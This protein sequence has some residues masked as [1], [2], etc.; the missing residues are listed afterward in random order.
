MREFHCTTVTAD[1]AGG[2]RFAE[3]RAPMVETQFAPPA[4][5]LDVA[6]LDAARSVAVIAGDEAWQG[7]IPHPAPARQLLVILQGRGAITVSDGERR[8][9]AP[10]DCILVEDTTGAGH[11]SHFSGETRVLVVRLGQG[12]TS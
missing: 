5:P 10:G 1:D 9:F 3:F 2:S 12:E 8:E 4:G 7:E 6:D 11:S